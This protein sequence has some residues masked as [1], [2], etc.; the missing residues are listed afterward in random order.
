MTM[1]E[2]LDEKSALLSIPKLVGRRASLLVISRSHCENFYDLN[3]EAPV[4]LQLPMYTEK[5]CTSIIYDVMKNLP[6]VGEDEKRA[7]KGYVDRIVAY[8]YAYNP[9]LAFIQK[10][11]ISNLSHFLAPVYSAN[12]K[13]ASKLWKLF[14]HKLTS[15]PSSVIGE[16]KPENDDPRM[17]HHLTATSEILPFDSNY[18]LVA[19]YIASYNPPASD[20]RFFV[21]RNVNSKTHAKPV[22]TKLCHVMGPKPFPFDR[23]LAILYAIHEDPNSCLLS[24]IMTQISTLIRLKLLTRHGLEI[25]DCPKFICLARYEF[26]LKCAKQIDFELDLHLYDFAV[27][28]C[29]SV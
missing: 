13:D 1:S 14:E 20:S 16:I 4:H 17:S 22:I 24:N 21:K 9:D 2:N 7:L 5:E 25:L 18:I 28:H 10:K 12:C 6:D 26:V 27:A 23:L 3:Y 15:L 29:T 8:M 19:S 11:S